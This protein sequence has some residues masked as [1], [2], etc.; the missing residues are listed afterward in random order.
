MPSK[1]ID[2]KHAF[3]D[4]PTQEELSCFFLGNRLRVKVRRELFDKVK[5]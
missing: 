2:E 3:I 1:N 4:D 5:L